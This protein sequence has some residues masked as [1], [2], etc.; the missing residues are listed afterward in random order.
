MFYLGFN[1]DLYNF[2]I[3]LDLI[4]TMQGFGWKGREIEHRVGYWVQRSAF[5]ER[6][7]WIL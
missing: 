3:D 6:S 5:H 4:G 2:V 1:L 7:S